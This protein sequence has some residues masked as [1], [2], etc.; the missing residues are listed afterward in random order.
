MGRWMRVL[1]CMLVIG[2][3]SLPTALADLRRGD[4]G[5]EVEDLQRML[6]EAGWLFELPDGV[7]GRNTEKAVKDYERYAGFTADGVADEATVKALTEDWRRLTQETEPSEAEGSGLQDH[8]AN[9]FFCTSRF[10][11]EGVGGFTY[12]DA[13]QALCDQTDRLIGSGT[14]KDA[15]KACALWTD[16]ISRLYEQWVA[17]VDEK[18]RS[19]IASARTQYLSS[20]EA[21][22]AAINAWYACFQTLPSADRVDATLVVSLREHAAWLCAMLCGQL[23]D[24]GNGL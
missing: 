12:C 21:H 7:F 23:A 5:T 14:Q 13:H 2:L 6:Y 19:A 1:C 10:E 22:R 18:D 20:I 16:E 8:G 24:D 4:R 9:P 3:V 11:V 15:Q 17:R